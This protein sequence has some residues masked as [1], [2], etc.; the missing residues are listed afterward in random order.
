MAESERYLL[1]HLGSAY[2][3]HDDVGATYCALDVGCAGV[4]DGDGGISLHQ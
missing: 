2:G 4:S 1:D 3:R